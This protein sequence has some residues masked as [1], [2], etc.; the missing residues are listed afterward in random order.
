[1]GH[2]HYGAV[3]SA[4]HPTVDLLATTREE[5]DP[6]DPHH[7]P[8]ASFPSFQLR[9]ARGLSETVDV[10]LGVEGAV[11]VVPIPF[12]ASLGARHHFY[13]AGTLAMT[14]SGRLGYAA[15]TDASG[16]DKASVVYGVLAWNADLAAWRLVRPG[17]ALSVM[18]MRVRPDVAAFPQGDLYVLS[19]SVTLKVALGSFFTPFVDAGLVTSENVRGQEL[20]VGVGASLAWGY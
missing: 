5:P 9:V 14:W 11:Y 15:A 18:P 4:D 12:G 10:E 17:L 20:H 2:G 19:S 16:T 7:Y 13:R 1:V 6:A 8:R 3:F